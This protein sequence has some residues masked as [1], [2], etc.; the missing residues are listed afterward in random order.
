MRRL[1]SQPPSMVYIYHITHYRLNNGVLWPSNWMFPHGNVDL[2]T[3]V[4]ALGPFL[5]HVDD[6][7]GTNATH[8]KPKI[9]FHKFDMPQI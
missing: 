4:K 3:P 8:G 5:R 6:S 7:S 2:W 1:L 9:P